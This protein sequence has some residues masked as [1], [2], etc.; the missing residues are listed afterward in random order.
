MVVQDGRRRWELQEYL[1]LGG[2]SGSVVLAI[3]GCTFWLST[4]IATLNASLATVV[5][6]SEQ[7]GTSINDHERR[8]SRMEGRR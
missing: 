7:H 6:Q 4:S 8:I 5:R 3:I 1:A 2:A